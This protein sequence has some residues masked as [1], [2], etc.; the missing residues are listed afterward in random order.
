[1][2]HGPRQATEPGLSRLRL[3]WPEAFTSRSR[4][5]VTKSSCSRGARLRRL[6]HRPCGQSYLAGPY[7]SSQPA[8]ARRARITNLSQTP[9]AMWAS[10][11]IGFQCPGISDAA[12]ARL[13]ERRDDLSGVQAPQSP[14]RLHHRLS[15]IAELSDPTELPLACLW[16]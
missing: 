7:A 14:P 10:A 1:M 2:R 13:V 15:A 5:S 11:L 6:L 9:V 12:A 4:R 8:S 16:R 3:R